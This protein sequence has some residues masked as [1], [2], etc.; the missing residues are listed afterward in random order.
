MSARLAV[1]D[2]AALA[3]PAREPGVPG[4]DPVPSTVAVNLDTA[5]HGDVVIVP[6]PRCVERGP[7]VEFQGFEGG[8]REVDQRGGR[9][10]GVDEAQ[11]ELRRLVVLDVDLGGKRAIR[12]S[13]LDRGERSAGR[14][15]RGLTGTESDPDGTVVLDADV[16]GNRGRGLL[17]VRCRW[18]CG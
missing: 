6:D 15:R 1:T 8:D 13:L 7:Q 11:S 16:G 12:R 14:R 3:V 2:A 4:P 10:V 18:E 5:P 9:F 17:R